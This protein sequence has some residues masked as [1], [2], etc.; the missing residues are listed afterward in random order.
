MMKSRKEL[1][2][3][4]VHQLKQ[5]LWKGEITKE[6]AVF[7]ESAAWLNLGNLSLPVALNAEEDYRQLVNDGDLAAFYIRQKRQVV[8]GR[9]TQLKW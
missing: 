3:S 6:Q 8:Q 2:D 1:Y 4:V 5:K 7:I 9:I